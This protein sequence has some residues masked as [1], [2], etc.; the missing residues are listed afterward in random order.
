MNALSLFSGIGGLDIAA[1]WA[2]FKTV[3]FCER[4]K[5]CKSVLAARWPG[6]QIE[7]DVIKIKGDG[8]GKL[9]LV[10]GGFPCQ[11]FSTGG[12]RL[13]KADDRYLWPEMFR[14]V[15]E[16]KP[17]WVVAEN[18]AHFARMALDDVLT[19]LE[20]EGYETWAFVSPACAVNAPHRRDRLWIVANLASK[21]CDQWAD[22]GGERSLHDYEKRD[23]AK[24]H[25]NRPQLL[26][27]SWPVDPDSGWRSYLALCRGMADGV[28]ARLDRLRALGNAV[29]PQQ[30]YPIFAA[31]AETYNAKI[32]GPLKRARVD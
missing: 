22:C 2:G 28:P 14:V 17:D 24:A 9:Q 11:P 32:T 20:S 31:I 16:A 3:A 6:I 8:F 29:V 12:K 15:R 21:R 4:D 30:A 10:H 13:G 19:D 27:Q 1:E 26:S 18:V 7:D 5:F 25:A 23:A